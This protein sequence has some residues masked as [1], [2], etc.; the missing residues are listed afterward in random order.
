VDL[1]GI[2]FAKKKGLEIIQ[3]PPEEL[4]RWKNV[5]EPVIEGYVKDMISKGY[6]EGEIRGW[7]A[8][9]RER[10]KYW[11]EKQIRYYIKSATGPEET[12]R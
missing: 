10:I 6:S 3:L 12:L 4:A 8:F 2:D 7:I 1:D 5:A 9:L 11:T